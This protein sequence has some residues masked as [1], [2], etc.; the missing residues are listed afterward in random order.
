MMAVVV[1]GGRDGHNATDI[2]RALDLWHAARPVSTLIHGA[3]PDH[4]V[5]RSVDACADEWAARTDGVLPIR[6]DAQWRECGDAAGPIRNRWMARDLARYRG[7]S[8]R[9]VAVLAFRGGVGTEGMIGEARRLRLPVWRWDGSRWVD[10]AE[11]RSSGQL[12]LGIE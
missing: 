8:G 7:F 2:H 4:G 3:C 10:D 11:R 9:D 6:V 12:G 1:T 5:G